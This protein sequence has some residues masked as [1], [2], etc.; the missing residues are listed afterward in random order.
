MSKGE[1]F[2][3]KKQELNKKIFESNLERHLKLLGYSNYQ[4]EFEEGVYNLV[5]QNE[6]MS[7]FFDNFEFLQPYFL[8]FYIKG[9]KAFTLWK[10]DEIIQPN[11]GKSHIKDNYNKNKLKENKEK[12]RQ[13]LEVDKTLSITAIAQELGITRQGL[14]K[15]QELIELINKLKNVN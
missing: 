13:L 6:P 3:N 14:Y 10:K 4:L 2:M 7:I 9:F 12:I 1:N 15:N 8:S 11:Q 5:F